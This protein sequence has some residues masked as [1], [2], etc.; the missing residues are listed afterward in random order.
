MRLLLAEDD[1]HLG[2]S[3][4]AALELDGY[5]VDWL[6]RGDE[7]A[8]A[9]ETADFDALI[10][11]IGLPG[12]S[13]LDLVRELRGRGVT[14]PV[15]LLTARDAVADRVQ[16]L[17]SGADD[18]LP[19]PFDMDELF[20]RLR[21]LL[22]RSAGQ[23]APAL[24]AGALALH[25]QDHTA[26]LDG[27]PLPL[28]AKEFAVLEML[29]RSRGRFVSRARLEEGLYSWDAEVGSNTVEVYI[30]RLRKRLGSAAIETLRGVGYRLSL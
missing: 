24:Q 14:V 4:R 16:G 13:G 17:D 19:K 25:P 15:L 10:L 29:A 18:Y 11:D 12:L 7:A 6:R 28:S 9:V 27:Q 20:A 30:S 2:E 23:A 8:A 21:S 3:L 1:P 26:T 5:A 22:R